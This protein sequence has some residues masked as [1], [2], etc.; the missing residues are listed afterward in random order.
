MHPLDDLQEKIMPKP[1]D[2]KKE[3]PPEKPQDALQRPEETL[4]EAPASDPRPT[5]RSRVED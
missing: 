4:G 1:D 2:D 3:K 5:E